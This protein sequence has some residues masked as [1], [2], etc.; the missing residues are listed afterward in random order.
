MKLKSPIQLTMFQGNR[1]SRIESCV[2]M[3]VFVLLAAIACGPPPPPKKTQP[4]ATPAAGTSTKAAYRDTAYFLNRMADLSSLARAWPNE[5]IIMRSSHDPSDQ[6][7]DENIFDKP[8]VLGNTRWNV[9]LNQNGPGCVTRLWITEH[10]EGRLRIYFDEDP[11]PRIDT[12]ISEFFSGTYKHFNPLLVLAPEE[13]GGGHV[14]YFPLPF[15]KR[16][17]I[18][19]DSTSPHFVYQVNCRLFEGGDPIRSYQPELDEAA[20]TALERVNN[21]YSTA[22]LTRAQTLPVSRGELINEIPP[23]QSKL[24]ANYIGPGAIDYFEVKL[25]TVNTDTVV[26]LRIKMFWDGLDAPTVD[27]TIREFFSTFYEVKNWNSI[28]LGYYGQQTTF[29]SQFYMPF[30][31]KAEI[32]LENTTDKPIKAQFGSHKVFTDVPKD[33]LYF[34]AKANMRTLNNGF[35]YPFFNYQGT[36]NFIGMSMFAVTNFAGEPL[37]HLKGDEYIY[38]DGEHNPQWMGTGTDHFFNGDNLLKTNAPFWNPTHGCVAVDPKMRGGLFSCF[39][40]LLLDSI[41]FNT[42]LSIINEVGSPYEIAVRETQ[43]KIPAHYEWTCYWYARPIRTA[44][45]RG[46]EVYHFTCSK[47]P[48]DNPNVNDPVIIDSKLIMQ[49][50]EKPFWIHMAPI[51]DIT[52]VQ[53]QAVK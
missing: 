49:I 47:N 20:K 51:W 7:E 14:S 23:K 41:P 37:I 42:S 31:E 16:C 45:R 22:A 32:Y 50:P 2:F 38:Q 28:F 52:Q 29:Y 34:Y 1:K 43:E 48:E 9:L 8:Y 44:I 46:E 26:G 27:C 18:I 30:L 12:T 13:S 36:G 39:R 35:I 11:Y 40:F 53:H 10:A 21:T 6:G 19:T 5:K 15:E 3:T 25:H 33:P 4:T 17:S 24:V